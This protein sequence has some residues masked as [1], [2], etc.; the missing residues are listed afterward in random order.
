MCAMHAGG[1]S[2]AAIQRLTGPRLARAIRAGAAEVLRRQ[3]Y[4]NEINVFPVP[5][6]DT[7][8]N[9][10]S[11]VLATVEAVRKVASRDVAAV[12]RAAADG[13]LNGAL[14][15]SG[16][17][18]AQ[19]LHGLAE[20]LGDRAAATTRDFARAA[21]AAAAAARTALHPPREGTILSVVTEWARVVEMNARRI[22]DFRELLER[23][24]A[25]ARTALAETPNQLEV[26]RVN[27]VVDAG[28]QGFVSF[29]EGIARLFADRRAA[30]MP[31]RTEPEEAAGGGRHVLAEGAT[32][33]RYCTEGLVAGRR[34]DPARVTRTVEHLGD[35]LVVAGGG[36]RLRVHIH[37]NRPQE[38]FSI[39][40]AMGQLER[41]KVED[42]ILQQ[43]RARG[44]R[45]ALVADSACELPDEVRN[46]LALHLVPLTVFLGDRSFRDGEDLA[47]AQF[48]RL[49]RTGSDLP[50][51]SQP[52]PAR[53]RRLYEQ[54]L[55]RHE[56]ILSLHIPGRYSGTVQA[57]RTAAQQVDP[58][59]IRVV[60]TGHVS[61]GLGLVAVAAGEALARGAG[62][63]QAELAAMD[64]ARRTAV[65]GA[66]PSLEFA[67]RG[68]RVSPAMAATAGALRLR[69]IICFRGGGEIEKAG[70][71]IGFRGALRRL[72]RLARR[73]AGGREVRA[74]VA[75]A[76]AEGDARW[77][78]ARVA[79][80]FGLPGVEVVP[81][82]PAL[83]AHAGPGTVALA[84][85]WLPPAR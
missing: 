27:G 56:A 21:R 44:G 5:D 62:L 78:A 51:T 55:E 74:M 2:S 26:L 69:P 48:Y 47:P 13:A 54:L 12:A 30:S 68:G 19:F 45:V 66:V 80:T 17:I 67:V 39:L 23:A 59:R 41:T 57:A 36:S 73:F 35:S 61:V 84:V 70:A 85:Q 76:D 52:P 83:G 4:L 25:A 10:A 11:T 33:F 46:D 28:A 37:T 16:A 64:A 18:F 38:L 22:N 82:G 72:E 81:V 50:S 63:D 49:L 43:V 20:G 32:E 53:F 24:L 60:D 34:L 3:G 40:G 7:G 58:R 31:V 1:T 9:L 6:A 15:N 29:L 79:G 8:T 42:M 77:L 14:G 75:H 71:A 65:W